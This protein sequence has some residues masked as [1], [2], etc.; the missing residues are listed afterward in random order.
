MFRTSP[1]SQT[2]SSNRFG[3]YVPVRYPSPFFDLS[4]SWYPRT[5][6]ELL[7]YA[8]LY[9]WTQPLISATLS[10]LARYPVTDVI[11]TD[12][13]DAVVQRWEWFLKEHLKIRSLLISV[14]LDM[15]VQGNCFL[16]IIYPFI[17]QLVCVSCGNTVGALKRPE[18]WEYSGGRFYLTCPKCKKRAPAMVRDLFIDSPSGIHIHRWDP[19]DVVIDDGGFPGTTQYLYRIP[20]SL[21][22]AI[23][24]GK[25]NVIPIVPLDFLEAVEQSKMV[26]FDKS[27]FRHMKRELISGKHKGWGLPLISSVLK[28]AFQ[29][30]IMMKAQECVAPE[31]LVE[32]SK[33]LVPASALVVGDLVKTHTG[34][35]S[36][37][38][39]LQT[40][41][42]LRSRGD[43][44]VK[45]TVQGFQDTPSTFSNNHPLLVLG[46]DSRLFEWVEASR[47][48]VGDRVAYPALTQSR[49]DADVAEFSYSRVVSVEDVPCEEVISIEVEKYHTFCVPGM[50]THN[51]ILSELMIPLRIVFPQASSGIADPFTNIW[52]TNWKTKIEAEIVRWR[53]DQNYIPVLPMPVGS[54]SI[55][56]EGRSFLLSGEIRMLIEMIVSA[57]E[58]PLEFVFSGTSYSASMVSLR[59]LENLCMS[60]VEDDRDL[61]K[62]ITRNV[63][64]AMD[65][66]EPK[67]ITFKPFKTADDLARKQ[68]FMAMA[69]R[70]RLSNTTLCALNDI[71]YSAEV[72]LM[73]TEAEMEAEVQKIKQRL[74]TEAQGEAMIVQAKYQVA[75]QAA[76]QQKLKSIQQAP[77]MGMTP[78]G[79]VGGPQ[80][81]EEPYPSI[82]QY[83][84]E[85]PIAESG[86]DLQSG[87]KG[88]QL[89]APGSTVS[90]DANTFAKTVATNLN[91]MD[92]QEREIQLARIKEGTPQ[93]YALVTQ[94][95][96]EEPSF[97]QFPEQGPSRSSSAQI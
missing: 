70:G 72:D 20:R 59:M 52:M 14:H 81:T 37:I 65:W 28:Y 3:G 90:V 74:S 30:Q 33:G 21:A 13:T 36:R 58:V 45:V 87:E 91:K 96:V 6:K 11:I 50:A 93:L 75:A 77:L 79:G 55:G 34:I 31:T 66:P 83:L 57:L 49:V 10:K 92:P 29:L 38:S 62:W 24:M 85:S 64:A 1:A 2:S 56:G 80:Q 63:A 44:A 16:S 84:P 8:R 19:M 7:Q 47:V 43:F 82:S 42:M 23:K 46:A 88:M 73:K 41:P 17:R 69:D 15:L 25:K 97:G 60:M 95:M 78:P 35:Y 86:F 39:A 32:T 67:D 76:A 48:R 40:R 22:N 61:V 68:F 89:V 54:Q 51:T 12:K 4:S 53:Q 94:A 18:T 5:T 27:N 9:Y 71:D 26:V